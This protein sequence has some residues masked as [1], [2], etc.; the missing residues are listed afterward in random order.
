M[1]EIYPLQVLLATCAGWMNRRQGEIHEYLM[2]ENRVLKE[3][4]KGKRLRLTDAPKG[5]PK[6]AAPLQ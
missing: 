2:E 3:Q 1:A 4:L 5:P 6:S